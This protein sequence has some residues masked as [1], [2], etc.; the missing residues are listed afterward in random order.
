VSASVYYQR[1]TGAKSRRAVEV[2]RL[3]ERIRE[4]HA[5]RPAAPRRKEQQA[6]DSAPPPQRP[7]T[8]CSAVMRSESRMAA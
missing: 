3:L 4:L 2:E 5:R 8:S 7:L 1:R 6:R